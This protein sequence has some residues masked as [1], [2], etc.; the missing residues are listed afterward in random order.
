MLLAPRPPALPGLALR[1]GGWGWAMA[2]QDPASVGCRL[3]LGFQ[4]QPCLPGNA[5]LL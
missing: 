3:K 1:D 2:C 5:E 4:Q